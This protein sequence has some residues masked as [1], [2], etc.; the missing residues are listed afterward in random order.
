ML[1]LHLLK[2]CSQRQQSK[3]TEKRRKL[4]IELDIRG[5]GSVAALQSE[6]DIRLQ[7]RWQMAQIDHTIERRK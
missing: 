1:E 3:H 4:S 2:P 6:V 7:R 5:V